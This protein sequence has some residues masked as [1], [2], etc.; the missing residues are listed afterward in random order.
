MVEE[1]G[2]SESPFT[3][4][5]V[6]SAARVGELTNRKAQLARLGSR[7]AARADTRRWRGERWVW[8]SDLE[9]WLA[10]LETA[11]PRWWPLSVEQQSAVRYYRTAKADAARLGRDVSGPGQVPRG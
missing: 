11:D 5:T 9:E 8:D 6:D 10:L 4:T 1:A 7:E 2:A 3:L